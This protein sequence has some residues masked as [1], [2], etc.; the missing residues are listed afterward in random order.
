MISFRQI[1]PLH[2]HLSFFLALSV[3]VNILRLSLKASQFR[4]LSSL[5]PQHQPAVRHQ[6]SYLPHHFYSLVVFI[7][8]LFECCADSLFR[9]GVGAATA[10][11][12]GAPAAYVAAAKA[13]L[14]VAAVLF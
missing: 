9:C 5:R 10:S 13:A 6:G 7:S 11:A 2:L 4:W 3:N 14:H 1:I 8:D 12:S